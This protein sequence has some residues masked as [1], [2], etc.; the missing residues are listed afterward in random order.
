ML[1]VDNDQRE[2]GNRREDRRTRAND[3]ARF[4]TLDAVPLLR[5]LFIGKCRV[6]DGDFVAK[7]LVQIGGNCG[8]EADFRDKKNGGASGIQ[9]RTHACEINRS[10]ARAGYAV[11]K[12]TGKLTSCNR[13]AQAVQC[14]LLC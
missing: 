2:V 9:H 11:Q 4:S 10:F 8:R 5:S 7:H 1:F 3:H 6:Q 12:N 13:F 14:G